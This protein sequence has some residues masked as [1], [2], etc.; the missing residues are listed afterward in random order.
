MISA[1]SPG[2]DSGYRVPVVTA[3]TLVGRERE[4]AELTTRLES[5][6]AGLVMVTGPR[7]IVAPAELVGA[8]GHAVESPALPAWAASWIEAD[9]TRPWPPARAT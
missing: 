9:A 7:G 3:S 6:G 4:R 5:A 2:G 1:E 8:M